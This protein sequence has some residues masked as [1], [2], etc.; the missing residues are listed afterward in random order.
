MSE[1][2]VGRDCDAWCTR[3]KME[4]A[5]TIV[6]MVGGLPVQVKCNTCNGIHK[7]RA[8]K[9]AKGTRASSSSSSAST[10]ASGGTSRGR[11]P[12]AKAMAA[13]ADAKA[14]RQ[15]WEGMLAKSAGKDGQRYM[16]T[17]AYEPDDV[18]EHSKFGVGFVVEEVSFNRIKVL[19]QDGERVLVARHGQRPMDAQDA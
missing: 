7:Y 6:A 14:I 18:V 19:F 12:S 13:E 16:V 5:H 15:R 9:K 11:A 10:R 8:P 17:A 1:F 2:A 3:C 4:L